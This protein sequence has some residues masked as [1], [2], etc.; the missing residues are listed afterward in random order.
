MTVE[1]PT[2]GARSGVAGDPLRVG[3]VGFN[4][5]TLL[6]ALGPADMFAPVR[7]LEIVM[8]ARSGESART[9]SGTRSIPDTTFTGKPS[10]DLLLVGG[11]PGTTNL[12]GDHAAVGFAARLRP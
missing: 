1:T 12:L 4:G 8:V 3:I 7:G 2:L 6:D 5:M 10:L 11:G 9:D